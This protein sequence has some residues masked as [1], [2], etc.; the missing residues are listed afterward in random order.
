MDLPEVDRFRHGLCAGLL[1]LLLTRIIHDLMPVDLSLCGLLLLLT[2]SSRSHCG[3]L[4]LLCGCACLSRRL[5]ARLIHRL[6][7]VRFLVWFLS[8]LLFFD[9]VKLLSLL[10]IK[11]REKGEMF[12]LVDGGID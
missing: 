3:R 5:L 6:A 12:D 8:H 4:I 7:L 9:K 1:L 2:F 11:S 10:K